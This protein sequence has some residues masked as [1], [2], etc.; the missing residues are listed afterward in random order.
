M[1]GNHRTSLNTRSQLGRGE[2]VNQDH[3]SVTPDDQPPKGTNVKQIQ[4]HY[5]EMNGA[6]GVIN[7]LTGDNVEISDN[8]PQKMFGK[9]VK[10]DLDLRREMLKA[11]AQEMAGR[12]SMLFPDTQFMVVEA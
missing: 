11:K 7:Y 8:R 6:V 2:E 5:R 1:A 4:I 10:I 9:T 3:Q 12:W